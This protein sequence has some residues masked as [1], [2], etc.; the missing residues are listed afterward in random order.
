ME[1]KIVNQSPT[2]EEVKRIGRQLENLRISCGLSHEDVFLRA[3]GALK[4]NTIRAIEQGKYNAGILQVS[5]YAN[6]LGFEVSFT[7]KTPM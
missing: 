4:M 7:K 1:E 2:N 5:T 3:N 6:L